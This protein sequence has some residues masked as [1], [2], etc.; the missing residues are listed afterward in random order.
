VGDELLI[1]DWARDGELTEG[2]QL[3]TVS[4]RRLPTAMAGTTA[5]GRGLVSNGR[6]GVDVIHIPAGGGFEPH[7]HRGDH[8][9]FV[10]AGRGTITYGG[11][12]IPTHAGQVYLVAGEVAHAVGAITDHV[13]LAVGSPHSPVDSPDRMTPVQYRS[14]LSS[15]GTLTCDICGVSGSRRG[16][17]REQGCPHDPG[18]VASPALPEEG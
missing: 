3:L 4:P 15:F 14:V 9:L 5:T 17:L 2:R 16:Q 7:T 1:A 12:I 8:L 13:L 10:I 18:D 11:R 6:L